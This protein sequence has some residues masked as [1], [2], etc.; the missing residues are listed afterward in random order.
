MTP[1]PSCGECTAYLRLGPGGMP[2]ALRLTEVLGHARAEAQPG[3]ARP[4]AFWVDQA[5]SAAADRLCRPWGG[6]DERLLDRGASRDATP[7]DHEQSW[8]FRQ[9]IA[10]RS[11]RTAV[12]CLRRHWMLC[13]A[14]DN[15]RRTCSLRVSEQPAKP[16]TIV[17][18]RGLTFEVTWR[19]RRDARPELQKMYTVPAARAWWHAVGSQVDRGVRPHLPLDVTAG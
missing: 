2:L 1:G 16:V 15:A 9:T 4:C 18:M 3:G 7:G 17:F 14:F 8:R 5:A 11:V 10:T 12:N 6:A 13:A 19:R